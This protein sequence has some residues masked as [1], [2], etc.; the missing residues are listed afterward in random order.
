MA[1]PSSNK[2]STT[3]V[4]A[5]TDR[6]SNAREDIKKNIDNVND[7]IDYYGPD[8]AYDIVGTYNKQQYLDLQTLTDAT[9]ISWDLT[10]AQVAEI[11][12]GGNRTLSNPTN[13]QPG[14]TYVLIVKQPA[15]ANY[16]LTFSSDYKFPSDATPSVTAENGAVDIFTFISDGTNLYGAFVQDYS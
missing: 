11:T 8:G 10:N 2:A 3:H 15:G 1:W 13:K 9:N 14:A 6:I 16:S 5:G 12:L 4:D 7:I